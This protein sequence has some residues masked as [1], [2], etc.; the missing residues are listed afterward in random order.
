MY[1]RKISASPTINKNIVDKK[2]I[3]G[4]QNIQPPFLSPKKLIWPKL[5]QKNFK[6]L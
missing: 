5:H 2:V 4:K 6:S 3:N 1:A